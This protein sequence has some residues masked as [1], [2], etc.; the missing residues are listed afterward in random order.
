MQNLTAKH[1]NIAN[2]GKKTPFNVFLIC[3]YNLKKID[4]LQ[5]Y[6]SEFFVAGFHAE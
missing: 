1:T 4:I 3:T 5:L 6:Q 2:N